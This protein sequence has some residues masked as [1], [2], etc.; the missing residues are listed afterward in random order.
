MTERHHPA[1]RLPARR[2]SCAALLPTL[3]LP[4][5]ALPVAPPARA[6]QPPAGVTLDD[7]FFLR[8]SSGPLFGFFTIDNK[9]DK[10]LLIT[11]WASPGCRSLKLEE[12]GASTSQRDSDPLTVPPATRM[13]FA[14]GGYHLLCEGSDATA[15][16]GA[17]IDVTA[18]FMSG[19]VLAGSFVI[20]ARNP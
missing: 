17:K 12:S 14:P 3:A 6:A 13:V 9:S 2:N 5:L 16:P 20:R 7:A 11:A 8:G 15:G 4:A 18:T 10:P 1:A 19:R